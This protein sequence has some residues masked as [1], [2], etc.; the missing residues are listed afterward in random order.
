MTAL[1]LASAVDL[2]YDPYSEEALRDPTRLYRQ[3]RNRFPAYPLPQY[4]AW[5]L[6]RFEDIWTVGQDT[7]GFV[8]DIGPIYEP[9]E[10]AKFNRGSISPAEPFGGR[11]AS[12]SQ[13]DPPVHTLIRRALG[14]PLLPS[15][16]AR[17][18]ADIRAFANRRLD[19]LVPQGEFDIY[20]DYA[21][22]VS[23]YV[24]C[25]IVGLP[26][27]DAALVQDLVSRGFARNPPGLTPAAV[28]QRR[29]LHGI[30]VNLVRRRRANPGGPP[31]PAIDGLMRLEIDGKPLDDDQIAV[32]LGTITTGGTETVPKVVA[33]CLLELARRPEQLRAVRSNLSA[34]CRKA[35][36]EAMRHGAPLQYVG[37]T[38]S[39]DIEI[40]GARILAG[41][42]LFLLLPSGN[43]DEREF[44][45][46]D[47]F[48]W[49]RHM[50]RHLAFGYGVHFCIGA[51]IARL[52]GRILLEELLARIADYDIDEA[53][54]LMPPSDFQIGYVR[55][56]LRIR[57]QQENTGGG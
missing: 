57:Q 23:A 51:H 33:R 1:T 55:M 5:A 11:T 54:A 28:E 16:V 50:K 27:E 34:N 7:A 42:R 3:L 41:Q 36:E 12:F 22:T 29:E 35:F 38:A 24:M 43:R 26:V 25:R 13:L 15:A 40:A 2:E 45:N 56:P 49:N 44:S 14:P 53:R 6:S 48:I 21:G 46:P 20:T 8:M 4:D 18:E 30:L 32:Q 19:T 52:E 31:M 9:Q 37:R 10:L 39:R 47:E 17:M